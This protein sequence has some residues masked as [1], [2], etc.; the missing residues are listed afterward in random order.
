MQPKPSISDRALP[1]VRA[2]QGYV[3][4]VQPQ[5]DGWIKLNTNE[6]PYPPSP[7]VDQ[8]IEDSTGEILKKY[9]S[10]TSQA[11]RE[12]LADHFELPSADWVFVGN[13]SDEVLNLMIRVFCDS[14]NAGA[15]MVPS[16]SLYPILLDIQN[17]AKISVP[18]DESFELP[19]DAVAACDAN[20][21]FLTSPN[22]PS[23]VGIK[24]ADIEKL[25]QAF[26]GVLLI[27]EA[28][29]EFAEENAVGLLE[30]YPN[31]CVARTFS[32]SHSLAGMRIGCLLGNPELIQLLDK[33]RDSYNVNQLSQQAGL[34]AISD[35]GYY[36]GL[37]GKIKRTRDF[38][39]D[40][41]AKRG[42][43]VYPSQSNYLFV[44][45]CDDNGAAGPEIAQSLFQFLLDNK[46]L[47][48]YFGNNP[49]THS[50]LRIS[51][52]SEDEMLTLSETIDKWQ[53]N[54]K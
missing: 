32:K 38:Y 26:S 17:A 29:A 37:V 48:R 23:G 36:Q 30:Q 45:P 46:I 6:N 31:L 3:P 34:A 28:Y 14:E 44:R 51:V 18:Y 20:V 41:F 1:H 40:D 11:L 35:V 7:R 15:Y 52:G 8:A 12:K 4:G 27:D 49:L 47:V 22:A 39:S 13:G 43:F 2:L 21:F 24:T 10:P 5:D 16:Y 33:V 53:N 9:P 50:F 54:A 19:V 42:W 25:A